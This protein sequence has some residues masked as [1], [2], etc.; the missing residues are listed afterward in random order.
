M[1]QYLLNLVEEFRRSP[2]IQHRKNAVTALAVIADQ[3]ATARLVEVA[4]T[5][6][7][8]DVRERAEK[9][10]LALGPNVRD[11][12][13]E[14]A[15]RELEQKKKRQA[16]Y[17]MLGR[18]RS[19][20]WEIPFSRTPFLTWLRLSLG[21]NGQLYPLRNMKFRTRSWKHGL[22]GGVV[23]VAFLSIVFFRSWQLKDYG[24][25]T[26][27]S[28][29]LAFCSPLLAILATQRTSPIGLYAH[30]LL[31]FL[32]ETVTTLFFAS[33]CFIGLLLLYFFLSRGYIGSDWWVLLMPLIMG[34]FVA[35]VRGGTII[36]YG[37]FN[38][39]M[40][41]WWTQVVIGV[42][43]GTL[44]LTII[45]FIAWGTSTDFSYDTLSR[46]IGVMWIVLFPTSIITANAFAAIDNEISPIRPIIGRLGTALCILI[47]I[48]FLAVTTLVF[49]LGKDAYVY[50]RGPVLNH[51]FNKIT[52]RPERAPIYPWEE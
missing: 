52:R 51:V 11:G 31:G 40:W 45:N 19:N 38:N 24:G 47:L 14:I 4:L 7:V 26:A 32:T 6:L 48:P 44:L 28:V 5:D 39:R 22:L 16:A 20:G 30:H 49:K 34:V 27:I 46:V 15:I 36:A 25:F 42:A 17:I 43:T 50:S 12:V 23:A 8:P 10:I 9:E 35:I 33:L 41:N 13:T 2:E 18:F 29:F 1:S 3:E 37:R 21:L